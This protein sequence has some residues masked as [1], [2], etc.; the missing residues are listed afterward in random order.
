MIKAPM[1]ERGSEPEGSDL[2]LS[3]G[4]FFH[5][6]A[7]CIGGFMKL[8]TA[9]V[10][11][12]ALSAIGGAAQA[13]SFDLHIN[14][15]DGATFNGTVD[16]NS[17]ESVVQDVNGTLT[18]YSDIGYTGNV[19][20]SVT[21]DTYLAPSFDGYSFSGWV[22]KASAGGGGIGFNYTPTTGTPIFIDS[23]DGSAIS[24]HYS[25]S[26]GGYFAAPGSPGTG[27]LPGGGDNPVGGVPEPATWAMILLGFGGLGAVLR[28]Q[29]GTAALA[30]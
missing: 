7:N 9:F 20:D 22:W 12:L 19:N 25:Q 11:I 17:D 26:V 15:E 4:N 18:G 10:T 30:A 3:M 24:D 2:R 8:R 16:F 14:Y 28:G 6:R 13:A 1:I 5:Q 23:R 27:G 21:I 29:R